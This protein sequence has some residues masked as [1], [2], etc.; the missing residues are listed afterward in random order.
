MVDA[1][2]V[3]AGLGN[4]QF[5]I[6]NCQFPMKTE[7]TRNMAIA[8]PSQ[9]PTFDRDAAQRRVR[10][11]LQSLR[12]YIRAFVTLEGVSVA[13]LFLALWFW[14]GIALDYGIFQLLQFD[15]IQE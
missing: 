7:R 13:V 15:W 12:G 9:V 5:A 10:H 6:V 4:C 3:E 11:P 2:V 8:P 14:I 1:K